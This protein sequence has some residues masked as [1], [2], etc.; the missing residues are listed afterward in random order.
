MQKLVSIYLD[1]AGYERKKSGLIFTNADIHGRVAEHLEE[2][3]TDG[4]KITHLNCLNGPETGG[5]IVAALERED[6][7]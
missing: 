6:A 4:W 2:Y 3:L 1:L 7:A 5:W